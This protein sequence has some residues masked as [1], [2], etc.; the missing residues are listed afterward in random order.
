L[1]KT[2]PLQQIDPSPLM[3]KTTKPYKDA[4]LRRQLTKHV[5]WVLQIDFPHEISVC[6]W[7]NHITKSSESI[8]AKTLQFAK[9]KKKIS[10]HLVEF[11]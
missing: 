4:L 5:R 8:L 3:K 1:F 9:I 10:L 6:K 7:T 2:A 11:N